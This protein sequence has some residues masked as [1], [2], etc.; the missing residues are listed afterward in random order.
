M[1]DKEDYMPSN[2]DLRNYL[3][4]HNLQKPMSVNPM[5]PANIPIFDQYKKPSP[6][7]KNKVKAGKLNIDYTKPIGENVFM[8]PPTMPINKNAKG[9]TNVLPPVPAQAP[10]TWEQDTLARDLANKQLQ[11][12]DI[13]NMSEPKSDNDFL[14]HLIGQGAA[15][16][17]AGIAGRDPGQVANQFEGMRQSRDQMI[18]SEDQRKMLNAE[19]KESIDLANKLRDPNSEESKQR[20]LA[21]GKVLGVKIPDEMSATDLENPQV[22]NSI[23]QQKMMSMRASGGGQSKE[24]KGKEAKI[25]EL[26]S[27]QR[28]RLDNASLAYKAILDLKQAVQDKEN[29]FSLIG[30]ND[31]TEASRRF[32]EGMGRMQSGGAINKDEEERF[33][34]LVPSTF[35]SK[36][37]VEKKLK[38]MEN[39]LKTRIKGFGVDPNLIAVERSGAEFDD[40]DDAIMQAYKQNPSDPDVKRLYQKMIATKR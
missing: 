4:S 13:D 16:F 21:Y 37:M 31:Y 23:N 39:E 5:S 40:T 2:I 15:M 20:R 6:T 29:K 18:S 24:Q 36:E 3:M 9:G 34:K 38:N 19:R 8:D 33:G 30:D 12:S 22:L 28:V 26:S 32:Q 17:G 10:N 7:P 27:E 11:M 25:K 14:A 1:R 35:D